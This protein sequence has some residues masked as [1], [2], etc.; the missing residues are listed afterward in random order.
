MQHE[1]VSKK[2][3]KPNMFDFFL[4]VSLE[5]KFSCII[6]LSGPHQITITTLS[7]VKRQKHQYVV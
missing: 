4:S 6:V 1:D 3:Q 5:N 2:K 7:A